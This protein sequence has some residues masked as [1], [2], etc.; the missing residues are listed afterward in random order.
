MNTNNN[1]KWHKA[2]EYVDNMSKVKGLFRI[3]KRLWRF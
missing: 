1:I 2:S 3:A